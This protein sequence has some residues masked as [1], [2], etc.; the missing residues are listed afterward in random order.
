ME[1]ITN[2]PKKKETDS[3]LDLL[4][5]AYMYGVEDVSLS[6]NGDFKA[7][8]NKLEKSIYK[9]I[10]GKTWVDRLKDTDDVKRIVVSEAHRVFSDGQWDTADGKATH[11]IWHTREDDKV[12]DTHWYIDNLKVGI[13][14]YFY[15]LDGDRALKPY[16]FEEASNNVNCRCFLEYRRE[17]KGEEHED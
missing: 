1:E 15:T 8:K 16:G 3:I 14:D 13:N 6:L 9:K 17:E 2:S 11:K 5:M 4:I 12:R 10:D 7:D